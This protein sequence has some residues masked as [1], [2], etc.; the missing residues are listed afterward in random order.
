[1]DIS[2]QVQDAGRIYA[3]RGRF[4]AHQVPRVKASLTSAEG[5]V[6]LD[7]A[8]VSFVDSTG[9]AAL[10]ALYKQA[11][12]DGADFRIINIQDQVRV[13]FEITH[14]HTVLPLEYAG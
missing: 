5:D 10:V 8:E 1:M 3:L 6:T 12:A 13:I 14:L 11:Q 4:D 7:F 9:L 2:E